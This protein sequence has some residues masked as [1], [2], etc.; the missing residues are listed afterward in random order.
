MTFYE[1]FWKRKGTDKKERMI[2]VGVMLKKDSDFIIKLDMLP[3]DLWKGWLVAKGKEE[4][5]DGK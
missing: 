1:V 3:V 4:G 2:K 5:N